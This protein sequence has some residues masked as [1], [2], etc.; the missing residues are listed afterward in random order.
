MVS[1]I[2]MKIPPR[3]IS[4]GMSHKKLSSKKVK[5]QMMGHQVVEEEALNSVAVEVTGATASEAFPKGAA[6]EGPMAEDVAAMEV[7]TNNKLHMIKKMGP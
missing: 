7:I 3:K 1:K 4:V 6:E 5:R 2:V